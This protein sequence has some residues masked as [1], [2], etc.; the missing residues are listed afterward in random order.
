MSYST[1]ISFTRLLALPAL[2][3]AL[4]PAMHAAEDAKADAH[5]KDKVWPI[6]ETSC[7]GCHGEKKQKGKL[8]LDSKEAWLKGG[9]DG[10]IVVPG[11][12]AK[13]DVITAIKWEEKD[14]DK[15]MPPKKDK[16]LSAEQVAVIEEWVKAGMPWPEKK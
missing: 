10:K 1:R 12:P 11:D 4:A 6:I 13:S 16:K 2:T 3:L 5:F 7:V 14:T 15:N 8:R 9:E